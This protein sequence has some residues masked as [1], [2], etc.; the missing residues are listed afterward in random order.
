[1][2][3]LAQDWQLPP[4]D[5]VRIARAAV[6]AFEQLGEWDAACATFEESQRL[7]AS[8]DLSSAA[9]S[10]LYS[11][12][13]IMPRMPKPLVSAARAAIDSGRAA[14]SL[15]SKQPPP[16]KDKA[17]EEPAPRAPPDTAEGGTRS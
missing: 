14:R 6:D 7:E 9:R 11:S 5:R 13:H 4:R 15:I 16:E 12:P 17:Q 8:A 2:W 10:L 1:M 3:Q